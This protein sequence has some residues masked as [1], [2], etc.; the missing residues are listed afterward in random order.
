MVT[1][2]D[3]YIDNTGE[4]ARLR[5]FF[6]TTHYTN[7]PD[8]NDLP[9]VSWDDDDED[10]SEEKAINDSHEEKTRYVRTPEGA[11]RFHQPIGT[12]IIPG[13]DV[14]AAPNVPSVHS[15]RRSRERSPLALPDRPK[16]RRAPQESRMAAVNWKES[17]SWGGGVVAK[18]ENYNLVV[19]KMSG[20]ERHNWQVTAPGPYNSGS[21]P[22]ASGYAD[23]EEAAKKA[24]LAAAN[25]RAKKYQNRPDRDYENIMEMWPGTYGYDWVYPNDSID[26]DPDRI[27]EDPEYREEI[28]IRHSEKMGL[29]VTTAYGTD[30]PLDVN[31]HET[32]NSILAVHEDIFP[33]FLDTFDEVG[34][35]GGGNYLAYNGYV[36]DPYSAYYPDRP[37]Y[38]NPT[39]RLMFNPAYFGDT[40]DAYDNIERQKQNSGDTGWHAAKLSRLAEANPDDEP[41]RLAM[42]G[43]MTHEIGHNVGRI[44]IGEMGYHDGDTY[45]LNRSENPIAKDFYGDFYDM[46]VYYGMVNFE[47]DREE[48][49]N[50]VTQNLSNQ[51][52]GSPAKMHE[53][54]RNI[55]SE[56][57]S[58]YGSSSFH[59]MLAEVWSEYMLDP[60]PRDFAVDIGGLMESYLSQWLDRKAAFDTKRAKV[61]Q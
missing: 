48:F 11:R 28:A 10:S 26:P 27:M 37:G 14:T 49:I 50:A 4:K 38:G 43:T 47:M 57:L 42:M 58:T 36:R 20:D 25:K 13:V 34:T 59:E 51:M 45:K 60:K 1:N 39:T 17:W 30:V 24:A 12:P 7:E 21:V 23:T 19:R 40:D 5:E 18:H 46:L 33:G 9:E 54:D 8:E 29:R 44:V 15:P 56:V 32:V 61:K 6:D 55:M 3:I 2:M 16:P 52:G 41:W 22:I 53:F 35:D 31:A